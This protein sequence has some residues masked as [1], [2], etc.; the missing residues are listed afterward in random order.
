MNSFCQLSPDI[1]KLDACGMFGE[2]I[3]TVGR[4]TS[5]SRIERERT[6]DRSSDT[7]QPPSRAS[8]F[9]FE[10]FGWHLYLARGVIGRTSRSTTC[11]VAPTF[12]ARSNGP[13]F[14]LGATCCPTTCSLLP[15]S[16]ALL[17]S[18]IGQRDND[19]PLQGKIRTRSLRATVVVAT[20]FQ[21]IEQHGDRST[22]AHVRLESD[23]N[24]KPIDD[25]QADSGGWAA[26]TLSSLN[27]LFD[28]YEPIPLFRQ[29]LHP[30]PA[31]VC[32]VP[33]SLLAPP[34]AFVPRAM[35]PG[36][37][38]RYSLPRAKPSRG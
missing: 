3:G 23:F 12:V 36:L 18:I 30:V 19:D 6:R 25:I 24:A 27:R 2:K 7:S 8:L 14:R 5:L 31:N 11:L 33:A 17:F 26:I 10:L 16:F 9:L 32:T 28:R 15:V 13:I 34:G 37:L 38:T 1:S 4:T 35:T 29:Y 21:A 22:L 20:F